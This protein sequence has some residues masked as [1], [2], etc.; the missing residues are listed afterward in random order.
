[1][2]GESG[3]GRREAEFLE[4]SARRTSLVRPLDAGGATAIT[5]QKG[6]YYA[7]G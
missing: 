5:S 6:D 7:A 2:A 4:Q 3:R 1:M